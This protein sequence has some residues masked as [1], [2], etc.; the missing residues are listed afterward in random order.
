[1]IFQK[2]HINK[3]LKD[4]NNPSAPTY[5]HPQSDRPRPYHFAK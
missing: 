4:F 3:N 2:T 5:P 1:M